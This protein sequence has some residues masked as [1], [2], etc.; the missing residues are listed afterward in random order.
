MTRSFWFEPAR[1]RCLSGTTLWVV[2][3]LLLF[4]VRAQDVPPKKFSV[5]IAAT[6]Q[7]APPRITLNWINEGDATSYAVSRRTLNSGWQQLGTVGGGE[8]AFSD[9]NVIIGTPY[10][11]QIVKSTSKTYSGYGYLRAGIRVPTTEN[12]GK[13]ILVVESAPA[14]ALGS[15]V[16]RLQ[17][18]LSADG[19]VVIRRNVSMNDSPASVKEQIRSVYNS[20]PGNVKAL[21]LFGHVPVPYSGNIVPDGHANHEGAWPADVYYAEM[22]GNWTDRSVNVVTAERAANHNVPGDGKFDQ[23]EIPGDVELMVGRVD[24][25]NMT[26]YANKSNSRSEIDLLRQYLNKNHAFRIGDISVDRRALIC[27]NFGDKGRDPIAGSAWRTFP[28]TVGRNIHEVPWDGYLPAASGGSYLWSYASGGGTYYYSVGVATSDDFAL[29]DVKVVFAMFMGSYFGDWNNES[30][31]LR[32]ALGSGY[33]LTSSY[34][35]FPHTLYFAMG[36][37]EPIGY[38]IRLSQNNRSGGLYPPWGQ[39]THQVHLTL[40]GDPTLRLHPVRPPSGLNAN[41]VSGRVNLTWGASLDSNLQGYHLYRS[42]SAEG[43]F[44]RI[45]QQPVNGTSFSDTPAPGNYTYMVRAIKLEQTPGG[46]YLNPSLGVFAASATGGVVPQPPAAPV[47]RADVVSHAQ[48]NLQW[49]DL[50]NE[51]GYRIQRRAS[52]D[53]TDINS[54][55]ANATSFSDQGLSPSTAYSYRML[56]L[57]DAGASP[58]S[59]EVRVTTLT[60]PQPQSTVTFV[61]Q[62]T[63]TSGNWPQKFGRDG[64]AV[65]AGAATLP[66][67]VNFNGTQSYT[68][69]NT[70]DQRGL[71]ATATGTARSS[72]AWFG[73]TLNLDLSV[74]DATKRIALY[75]VDWDTAGRNQTVIVKDAATGTVMDTRAITGLAGGVY[76]VYDMRGNV[77]VT[78]NKTGGPNALLQG[79]FVGGAVPPPVSD[80]PLQLTARGNN[81]SILLITITGDS[82]QRFRLESSSDFRSWTQVTTGTVSTTSIEVPIQR[83]QNRLYLRTVNTP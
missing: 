29:Q 83:S 42:G 4:S 7:E 40:H 80:K 62:D 38:C 6:V 75:M 63:G 79:I 21:F 22:D 10:E 12:R 9:G 49:N 82:G 74:G 43:P 45:T 56:A 11:Y 67:A 33:I 47:L 81:G 15:E 1:A 51:T 25:H 71:L 28:G 30:N 17:R 60:A 26:C 39:G 37:G 44:T 36:L 41:P 5:Q 18:D 53:W 72:S 66:F 73:D 20:D 19:W 58:F 35:G 70:A 54:A 69:A 52:G 48:V 31:F 24:L 61:E 77:R 68:W 16:D 23:S 64:F 50:P 59:A 3:A 8:T 2:F 14:A 65:A 55:G 46:T 13:L 78:I 27:D 57:N 34:S 32:A 76:L